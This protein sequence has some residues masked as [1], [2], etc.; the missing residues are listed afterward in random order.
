MPNF[1]EGRD[2]AVIHQIACAAIDAGASLLDIH[3]DADHNRSVIT[4]A[5]APNTVV[6]A[7]YRAVETAVELLNLGTHEGVHPRIGVADVVPF[8]PVGKTSMDDCISAAEELAQ[9][10]GKELRLPAYLYEHAARRQEY[11]NLAH[12]RRVHLEALRAAEHGG[13]VALS[14]DE[15][16]ASVHPT[17]GAVAVGAREALVALN[18]WLEAPDVSSARRVAAAVREPASG[19]RGLKAL[20]LWLPAEGRAQVAMNVTDVNNTPPHVAVRAVQR[21]S[22]GE[23]VSVSGSELVGLIPLSSVLAAAA[24]SLGLERLE[25]RQVLE[26]A[27]EEKETSVEMET[28][29]DSL[30]SGAPAPGGGAASALAGA[31]GAAL[32]SMVCNLT[33]G[34]PKYVEAEEATRS[35]LARAEAQRARLY[36]LMHEDEEAYGDLL[37][38]YKL[39][40]ETQEERSR[41]DEKVEAALRRAAD[42]PLHVARAC[43][44]V[45]AVLGDVATLGNPNAISD[46]G[47]GAHLAA[48]AARASLLNVRTNAALMKDRAQAQE[49]L[50]EM[51]EVEQA[52]AKLSEQAV[53]TAIGRIR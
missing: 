26:L 18:C 24:D 19:L 7:A 5:G 16:P 15:G 22:E 41:R 47:A 10:L 43:M 33:I 27:M 28:F 36:G 35:L 25:A 38:Q 44:E 37:A 31:L 52:V 12:V 14:P 13:P 48:A 21:L 34:R 40:K 4:F 53:T 49:Y 51:E 8:V 39:P 32:A 20:G 29:L 6:Q 42:V 11:R 23:G 2:R 9:R 17:A 46:A 45:L 3:A 50:R 30:A 1:S